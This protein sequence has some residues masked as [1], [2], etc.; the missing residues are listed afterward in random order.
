[1]TAM[2]RRPTL[3]EAWVETMEHLVERPNGK[4]HHVV[5]AFAE[6]DDS[7]VRDEIDAV[8]AACGGEGG[9]WSTGTTANTI[10]PAGL[11]H[12]DLDGDAAPRLYES[13]D[14][15]MKGQSRLKGRHIKNS[16]FDRMVAYPSGDGPFNQL[17]FQIERLATQIAKKGGTLSSAYEIGVSCPQGDV[18]IQAPGIDRDLYSFPCLSHVSLTFVENAV[19]LTATYRNQLILQRGYGNFMGLARLAGFVANEVGAAAGE[20]MIVATHA[21][22][23]FD[24]MNKGT[25]RGLVES[26]REVVGRPS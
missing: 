18:R 20:V 16:Y 10:F 11:Y 24:G 3:T 13:H 21:D 5:V 25:V 17:Q 4:D 6:E 1:M 19:N 15:A 7:P 2:I 12:R 26:A 8:L 9:P 23:G 22:A 14:L